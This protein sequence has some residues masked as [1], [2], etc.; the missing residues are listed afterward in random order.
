MSSGELITHLLEVDAET[1]TSIGII[2]FEQGLSS[3]EVVRNLVSDWRERHEHPPVVPAGV[4]QVTL[5][6]RLAREDV[7]W[8][9]AAA[10]SS[11]RSAGEVV[12][13]IVRR[14][15]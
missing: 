5:R 9:E 12:A 10:A 15:R 11:G 14:S 6:L 7:D 1:R 3:G 2:G 8:L 13:E 4:P